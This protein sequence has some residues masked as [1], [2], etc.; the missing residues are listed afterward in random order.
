VLFCWALFHWELFSWALFH[1]ALYLWVFSNFPKMMYVLFRSVPIHMDFHIGNGTLK[2]VKRNFTAH[3]KRK[4]KF[5][6][7]YTRFHIE[8][9]SMPLYTIP[10]TH[11]Y[12]SPFAFNFKPEWGGLWWQWDNDL[13]VNLCHLRAFL[14]SQLFSVPCLFASVWSRFNYFLIYWIWSRPV[15]MHKSLY[16]IPK[17]VWQILF[18]FNEM[19]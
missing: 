16:N 2:A 19:S 17:Y 13:S 8:G 14:R 6:R 9:K 11:I 1:W 7:A 15:K 4:R 10:Y 5:T 3:A 12:T 18:E